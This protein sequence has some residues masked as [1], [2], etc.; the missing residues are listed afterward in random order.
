MDA[1]EGLS[2]SVANEPSTRPYWSVMVPVYRPTELL[3]D[4]LQSALKSLDQA[5]RS[6][7]IELV[8]DGT[9]ALDLEKLL[10][11]EILARVSVYRRPQNGGLGT[12]WNNCLDRAH[13]RFIHILHQDDCVDEKF[14]GQM[15]QAIDRHPEA[16]MVFCRTRFIEGEQIRLDTLECEVDGVLDDWISRISAG[17]RLQCPSVVVPRETYNRVGCFDAGLRYVIDWEMW[18]RIA[19]AF[20][21]VYV[22]AALA[23]YRLHDG[24]ETK[25]LKTAGMTTTDFVRALK[26][27]KQS[28]SSA[29]RLDCL[30]KAR[31]YAAWASA[32]AAL[33]AE[34]ASEPNAAAREIAASLR[35]FAGS[36]GAGHVLRQL[37]WYLR[38]R[39]SIPTLRRRT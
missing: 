29:G 35:Y 26:R 28:L 6:A 39:L 8:D 14:Y 27:I 9:P 7:Q 34:H 23:L 21:V 33:D 37:G 4:A 3:R 2:F 17:Q 36:M 12:C 31:L 16:G 38:L 11:S 25:R 30:P 32:Q 10:G 18:V 1:L 24:N 19:A 22:T 13:G 5:G 15:A 20:P